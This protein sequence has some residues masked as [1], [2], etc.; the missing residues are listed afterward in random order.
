MAGPGRGL[1]QSGSSSTVEGNALAH[2]EQIAEP[3]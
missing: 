2:D 1:V 3:R